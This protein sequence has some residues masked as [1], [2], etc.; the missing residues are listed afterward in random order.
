MQKYIN[1]EELTKHNKKLANKLITH[2]T[3]Y[4]SW[5]NEEIIIF[6]SIGDWIIYETNEGY[7][8]NII[9]E[10]KSKYPEL[11][12]CLDYTKLAQ[13]MNH[14]DPNYYYYDHNLDL[15]ILIR[16]RTAESLVNP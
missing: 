4:T 1:L 15:I 9:K 7:L 3:K 12:E 2:F 16:R 8:S 6:E 13:S 5:Q 11:Y 10:L 14:F